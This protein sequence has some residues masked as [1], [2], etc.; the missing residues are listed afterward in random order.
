MQESNRTLLISGRIILFE[1]KIDAKKL[2]HLARG[3]MLPRKV[4]IVQ[5]EARE[6]RELISA[7]HKLQSK[8]VALINSIRGMLKQE[9]Y[10]LPEKFFQN[11]NWCDQCR[12]PIS[13]AFLI[14]WMRLWT[15][16]LL[17]MFFV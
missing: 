3:D 16:N 15:L 14:A 10:K 12:R 2:A 5:G 13:F 17:Y 7:R 1:C 11:T 8:R 4:H 6:L 9:G